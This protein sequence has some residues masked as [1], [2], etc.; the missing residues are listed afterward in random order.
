[1]FKTNAEAK[2]VEMA[3]GVIRRTLNSG[4]HKTLVEVS[5]AKD[6]VVPVHTHHHEQIG[7]V[8]GGVVLFEIDGVKQE[9]STGDSYLVPGGVPHGVVTLEDAICID[10]FSPVRDEYL[11]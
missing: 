5:M 1:M 7:Y 8:A 2:P 3:P 11:D 10:I 9:L 4:D 6:S